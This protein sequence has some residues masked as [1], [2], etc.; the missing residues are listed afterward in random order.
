MHSSPS[1]AGPEYA[2]ILNSPIAERQEKDFKTAYM[3][4]VEVFKE[5]MIK[6]LK[7]IFEN[8][9]EQRKKISTTV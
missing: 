5:E 2:N 4:I 8:I 3:K 1:M 9:N 7:D 6:S